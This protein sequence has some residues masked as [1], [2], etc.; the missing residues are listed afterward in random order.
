[1]AGG[2]LAEMRAQ[3]PVRYAEFGGELYTAID[4]IIRS[5]HTDVAPYFSPILI[6]AEFQGLEFHG[7]THIHSEGWNFEERAVIF[8]SDIM[9][10]WGAVAIFWLAVFIGAGVD[11]IGCA[12]S[13]A[14]GPRGRATLIGSAGHA[15]C[16]VISIGDRVTID[17]GTT[18]GV[19]RPRFTRTGIFTIG[20]AIAIFI[21]TTL[22]SLRSPF[23]RAGV[24]PIQQAIPIGIARGRAT[25]MVS[26]AGLIGTGVFYIR[27]RIPICIGASFG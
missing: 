26:P 5:T 23:F 10:R 20:Y 11:I 17:I 19:S 15:R 12:I 21:G 24:V 14:V 6:Y 2:F 7:Y 16:Q 27:N 4:L 9:V 13:I 25:F 18:P 3:I 8:C 22:T 1:M